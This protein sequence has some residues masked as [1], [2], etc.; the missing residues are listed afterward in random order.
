MKLYQLPDGSW[1]DLSTITAIITSPQT[2]C[3]S[4][5]TFPPR[6]IVQYSQNRT[7]GFDCTTYDEAVKL[8]ATLAE[9]SNEER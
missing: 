9:K 2:L 7:T 8:A 4:G 1:L 3:P 5:R 6:V